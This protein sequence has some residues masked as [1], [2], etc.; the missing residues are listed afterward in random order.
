[1]ATPFFDTLHYVKRLTESG[2]SDVLAEAH[3]QALSDAMNDLA[4]KSDLNELRAAVTADFKEL[5]MEVAADFKELR[6]EVAADFKEL[7]T[8][9]AADFSVLRAEVS[10]DFK[11]F[12]AEVRGQ[13]DLLKWMIG[14]LLA[15]CIAVLLKIFL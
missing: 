10:A 13:F 12:R 3:S 1:M 4:R 14:F 9:V 11:E 7:R 15:S 5:R 6:M 2:L 8:E